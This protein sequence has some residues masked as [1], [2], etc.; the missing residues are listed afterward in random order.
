M[1]FLYSCESEARLC[2][3]SDTYDASISSY[4]ANWHSV[5]DSYITF[6]PTSPV[7]STLTT[8]FV[9]AATSNQAYCNGI[10]QDACQ[11]F[12]VSEVACL[13]INTAATGSQFL[14][15]ACQESLLS[16]ASVCLYDAAITCQSKS[17]AIL[18]DVPLYSICGVSLFQ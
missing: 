4:L 17:T 2:Y 5:C 18:G 14:S 15:C 13:Q 10:A 12:S 6:T 8:T 11:S 3:E 1:T 9:L 7:L 16:L